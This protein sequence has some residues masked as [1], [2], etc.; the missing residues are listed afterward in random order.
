MHPRHGAEH[1]L[2]GAS[3]P[4]R[5]LSSA[6]GR[7]GLFPEPA[8]FA[9]SGEDEKHNDAGSSQIPANLRLAALVNSRLNGVH[10]EVFLEWRDPITDRRA[11]PDLEARWA[12]PPGYRMCRRASR[13]TPRADGLERRTHGTVPALST[14]PVRARPLV[15]ARIAN[16]T[17]AQRCEMAEAEDILHFHLPGCH[18]ESGLPSSHSA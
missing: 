1:S 13:D 16:F 8:P 3:H 9:R 6:R 11:M 18:Q 2:P 15:A 4:Q 7:G 10:W 14:T 5:S 12:G 17:L